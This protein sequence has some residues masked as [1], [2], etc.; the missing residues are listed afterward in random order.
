MCTGERRRKVV[1]KIT[2]E[3]RRCHCMVSS[4]VSEISKTESILK[5]TPREFGDVHK[6]QNV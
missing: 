2:S 1:P 6:P 4:G 5:E 3:S